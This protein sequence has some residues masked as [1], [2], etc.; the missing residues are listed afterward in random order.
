M[1]QKKPWETREWWEHRERWTQEEIDE[2]CKEEYA[3]LDSFPWFERGKPAKADIFQARDYHDELS[4]ESDVLSLSSPQRQAGFSPF[5]THIRTGS[6]VET[7]R[8]G[9]KIAGLSSK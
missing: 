5:T 8:T 4:A 3:R 6:N 7:A 1:A 9:T 2:M